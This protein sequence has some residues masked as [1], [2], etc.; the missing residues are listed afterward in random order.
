M[1]IRCTIARD[2]GEP[3]T[4]TRGLPHGR[5]TAQG[6][7]EDIVNQIFGSGGGNSRQQN[8]VHHAHIALIESAESGAIATL[9]G[10]NE[11]FVINVRAGSSVH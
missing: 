6:L 4:E 5:K 3:R 9:R 2:C 1:E 7:Q 8:S 10:P 11:C